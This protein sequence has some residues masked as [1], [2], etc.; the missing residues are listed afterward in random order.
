MT[1]ALVFILTLPL[2]VYT[3]AGCLQLIDQVDQPNRFRALLQL[4]FRLGLLALLVLLTPAVARGWIAAGVL[5]VTV[6]TFGFQYGLRY[7]IRSGR[8]ITDRIE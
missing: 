6:L 3:W 4:T 1:A 5:T 8:W 7:A 2:T